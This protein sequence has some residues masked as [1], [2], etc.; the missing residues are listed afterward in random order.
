MRNDNP[1]SDSGTLG[2]KKSI[3]RPEIDGLRALALIAV[4]INHFEKTILPSG[5]LGVDIFFV[6]SGFV[7]TSSLIH[8][9]RQSFRH[10]VLDFYARRIKRLVPALVFCIV[11]T[12]ALAC[13]FDPSPGI[14]LQT[15]LA[16]LLGA[17][18]L[19]LFSQSTDYFAPSTELN[20]FTQTWSLGIEEQFYFLFPLL[21]WAAAFWRSRSS[22]VERPGRR[23]WWIIFILSIISLAGFLSLYASQKAAVYFLMP[24]RFWE[25]GFGCMLAL[26]VNR[27]RVQHPNHSGQGRHGPDLLIFAALIASFF[28]PEQWATQATVAAVVLTCLLILLIT[29][30]S[31][32]YQLLTHP[33]SLWIGLI[34]YSLYLWHWSILSLSN[35]TIGVHAWSVPFQIVAMIGMAT[36]SYYFIEKPLRFADWHSSRLITI[37][38]GVLISI[39]GALIVAL[40]GRPLEGK[41][42]LGDGGKD[43]DKARLSS[44]L[45]PEESIRLDNVETKLKQCNVTPFLLGNKSYKLQAPVDSTLIKDC[46]KGVAANTKQDKDLTNKIILIGDSFA[47]KLAPHM[48]LAARKSGYKFGMIYGYGCAYLLRSNL[49]KGASFPECRYLDEQMLEQ[50]LLESLRPGDLVVLRLHLVS[51]S[52]V[53]YPTGSSQPKTD[54]YDAALKNIAEKVSQRGAR[55]VVI[56][57]NPVLSKQE[58][59]ALKPEW[60]NSLNR[61]SS[62]PANNAQETIYFHQLD[63]HLKTESKQW[64]GGVY[65]SLKPYICEQA[66]HCLLEKEGR[67][68]YSDDHH[69][70][71]YGHDLIFPALQNLSKSLR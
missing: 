32:V 13:L 35:W 4:I 9:P 42:F 53:H 66:R 33:V 20:I 18:N 36:I 46:L 38:F 23:L 71:P 57:P 1:A 17:S 59:M 34:S 6:I 19:Y 10:G 47:E 60:F 43:T 29:K 22:V 56:G 27:Y 3:Y 61:A 52:Y 48:A 30:G 15:G 70:S 2:K 25:L 7:I 24:F 58:M 69:L 14:S 11:V 67:F 21:L 44:S 28:A 68:L 40:L 8:R 31:F 12:S 51:K 26:I 64:G 37:L 41:L 45:I 5:F 54:A 50:A 55:L 16:A 63:D 39:T 65:L 62:I 49:I